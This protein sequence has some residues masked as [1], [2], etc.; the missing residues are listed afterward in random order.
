ML[1]QRAQQLQQ[2]SQQPQQP[3]QHSRAQ[4]LCNSQAPQQPQQSQEHGSNS[5][6]QQPCNSQAPQQPQQP[7]QLGDPLALATHLAQCAAGALPRGVNGVDVEAAA[8][9]C[10]AAVGAARAAARA[11]TQRAATTATTAAAKTSAVPSQ[12]PHT[13]PGGHGGQQQQQRG[14]QRGQAGGGR[15]GSVSGGG[16][17]A[18]SSV[19]SQG[20]AGVGVGVGGAAAVRV[21]PHLL[22]DVLVAPQGPD[23]A[24]AAALAASFELL[25][26]VLK[27]LAA[28]P[29]ATPRSPHTLPQVGGSV[30]GVGGVEGVAA[31]RAYCLLRGIVVGDCD[32]ADGGGATG[33]TGAAPASATG[34]TAAVTGATAAA[35]G[36]A[37]AAT[38]GRWRMVGQLC[39]ALVAPG[40][41]AAAGQ[42][43]ARLMLRDVSRNQWTAAGKLASLHAAHGTAL[44][45]LLGVM[46]LGDSVSV[47]SLCSAERHAAHGTALCLLLGVLQLGDSAS[48]ASLRGGEPYP[49][50]A[51]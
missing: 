35:T 39:D 48:V 11:L 2:Q 20:P 50:P 27:A 10:L 46:Q 14:H 44:C 31:Q 25:A 13:S 32:S 51:P 4:Q 33:A 37:T 1:N 9:L 21:V 22:P 42:H 26:T 43:A 47:A 15:R 28:H 3:R 18:S 5:R 34:A 49:A 30:D 40:E 38:A 24:A 45:F 23:P 8:K 36:T 17:G 19:P 29:G 7:Q 6:A 12:Q 16:G 41:R